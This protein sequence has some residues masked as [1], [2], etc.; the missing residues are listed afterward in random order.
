MARPFAGLA[1]APLLRT[2]AAIMRTLAALL[3]ATLPLSACAAEEDIF[4]GETVKT[5]D[6]KDDSSSV[7]LFVD[8]EFDGELFTTSTWNAEQT[9]EDQLLY[10]IGQLNGEN[11]VGRLDTMKVTN[12]R[13]APVSG[14]TKL[15]YHVVLPV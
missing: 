14:G 1:M 2:E 12:I 4:E 15:T 11:S 9:I 8:F 6:G 10:T 3:A 7:A 13:S 5:E